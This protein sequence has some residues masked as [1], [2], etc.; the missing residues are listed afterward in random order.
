MSCDVIINERVNDITEREMKPRLRSR[1]LP[2][3]SKIAPQEI[4]R[5]SIVRCWCWQY[6]C[7]SKM[8]Q[9]SS[10]FVSHILVSCENEILSQF[11]SPIF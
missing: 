9:C 1:L 5:S 4:S 6:C 10:V 11:S 7:C 2:Y 8:S 3:F